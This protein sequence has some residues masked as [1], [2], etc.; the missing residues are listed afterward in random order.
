MLSHTRALG[1]DDDGVAAG[2]D[3]DVPALH[4]AELLDA[5]DVGPAR[6]GQVLVQPHA[7]DVLA[8]PGQRLVHHLDLGEV[9]DVAGE[10]RGVG[11]ARQDVLH[12]HLELR[13]AAQHVQLG[14][15]DVREAV[16]GGRV[17]ERHDVEPADAA[18]APRGGAVLE[19][20]GAQ[21]L[22]QGVEQLGGVGPGAHPG[23]VRLGDSDHGLELVG[24]EAEAGAHAAQGRVGAGNERVG[25][26]VEVQHGGVGAF[27]QHALARGV[28]LV[29][30]L[31]GVGDEG[32]HAL[33]VLAI[34]DDL[35]L[36]VVLEVGEARGGVGGQRAQT[37]LEALGLADVAHAEAVAGRL[38]G[39]RRA[40]AALGGSDLVA[41]QL[42]FTQAIHLLVEV[43]QHVRAVADHEAALGLDARQGQLVDLVEH[44]GQVHH[45]AV[46]HHARAL[47]VED[48]GR[49]QVQRV[50]LARVVV[51]G[52]PRVGAS[53]APGHDVVL[54]REDVHKLALALVA[55]LAA[56]HRAHGAE[57][58]PLL[59]VL[60]D[61]RRRRRAYGE[62]VALRDR[63]RGHRA[64]PPGTTT[65]DADGASSGSVRPALMPQ[66]VLG[67]DGGGPNVGR[68]RGGGDAGAHHLL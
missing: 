3:A 35:R 26:K 56:E 23:G 61:E 57:R 38:R 21:V 11:A 31:H 24:G 7:A 16:D 58:V 60:L 46:A 65:A 55:P 5:L 18:G 62:R 51:D 63:G 22:R 2:A 28:L 6:G 33:G 47:L 45:H 9:V 52:V 13:Q 49:D 64:A 8:P 50:F 39:V 36:H 42:C 68:N 48:A 12:A 30:H 54:L 1:L 20:L 25:A 43:K 4:L 15:V 10:R 66:A 17:V 53:L 41:G 19:P 44:A 32:L 29:D 27:H 37:R 14:E 59:F 67:G 40:D 34:P